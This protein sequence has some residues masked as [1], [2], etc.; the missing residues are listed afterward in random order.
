MKVK[1]LVG[2]LFLASIVHAQGDREFKA[3]IGPATVAN[4]ATHANHAGGG[5]D[6]TITAGAAGV[7]NCITSLDM[8][9]TAAAGTLRVLDGGTT[10]YA[11]VFAAGE[12]I[13]RDFD[14][15][16]PLCGTAA[17]AMHISYTT[18]TAGAYQINYVGYTY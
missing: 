5:T 3:S 4:S 7:R 15:S 18:S 10:I 16:G 1:L 8:S 2:L 9:S 6:A 13:I 17:T 11:V 12:D 14:A